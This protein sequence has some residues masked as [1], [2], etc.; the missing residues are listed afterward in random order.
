MTRLDTLKELLER[1]KQTVDD[2]DTDVEEDLRPYFN[3]K[4][5]IGRYC[6]VTAHDYDLGSKYFFLVSFDTLEQAQSRATEFMADDLYAERPISIVDLDTGER[7]LPVL[8]VHWL[9]QEAR[10]S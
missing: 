9:K 4:E 10:V 1:Y 6:C 7:W 3:G 8:D 5:E 2:Y